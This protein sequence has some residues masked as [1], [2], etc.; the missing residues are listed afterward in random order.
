MAT[1]LG[2]MFDTTIALGRIILAGI[3]NQYPRL[4]L[5]CPHVGGAMPYLVGRTIRRQVNRSLYVINR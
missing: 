1:M 5:V 3:P 4:K 2:L